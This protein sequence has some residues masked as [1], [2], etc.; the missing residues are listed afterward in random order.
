MHVTAAMKRM[1][2]CAL[3]AVLAAVFL[4]LP[5]QAMPGGGRFAARDGHRQGF[6]Q[7][8]PPFRREAPPQFQRHDRGTPGDGQRPQRLSPE[9][10]RQLRRD[11]HEAG[12]DIYA[13]RR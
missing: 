4:V 7:Q 6:A 2:G 13:P 5:A 3:L 8:P 10:R 9:E 1:I 11:V 12:Q